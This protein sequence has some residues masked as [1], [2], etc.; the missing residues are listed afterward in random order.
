MSRRRL[1]G[2]R[3]SRGLGGASPFWGRRGSQWLQELLNLGPRTQLA[4]EQQHEDVVRNLGVLGQLRRDV[5][6]S[7]LGQRNLLLYL[8][9]LGE[10]VLDLLLDRL[11]ARGDGEEQDHFRARLGEQLPG[12]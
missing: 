1:G 7:H 10:E 3:G 8:A 12:S 5:Q 2:S 6:L 4:V 9:P 11:L